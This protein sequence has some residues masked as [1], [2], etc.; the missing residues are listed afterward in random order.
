LRGDR[1]LD[2]EQ[3]REGA[4]VELGMKKPGP[5]S[6][7]L[8]DHRR[9]DLTAHEILEDRLIGPEG[10]HGE[11]GREEADEED[12]FVTRLTPQ[13][14]VLDSLVSLNRSAAYRLPASPSI[15]RSSPH[16]ATAARRR[17]S[18]AKKKGLDAPSHAPSPEVPYVETCDP[19]IQGS[20]N[21]L[22][23]VRNFSEIRR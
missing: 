2:Q 1:R 9:G 14:F 4:G 23:H 17:A 6:Q 19:S 5:R 3:V 7:V 11:D 8:R 15:W 21:C 10:A 22:S 20:V 12:H 13:G 18:N 16:P